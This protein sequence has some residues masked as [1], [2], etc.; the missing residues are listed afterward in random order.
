VPLPR[1]P[2]KEVSIPIHDNME[3]TKYFVNS[4][5]ESDNNAFTKV[6]L[7]NNKTFDF[8]LKSAFKKLGVHM[9]DEAVSDFD[10]I[11]N[12]VVQFSKP[13]YISEMIEA[14]TLQ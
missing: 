10:K 6:E 8:H 1:N 13:T 5:R 11:S 9:D 12:K 7:S 14:D 2:H 3:V 4:K